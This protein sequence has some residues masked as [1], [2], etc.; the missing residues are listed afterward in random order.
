MVDIRL[1]VGTVDLVSSESL[2]SVHRCE[3]AW[4]RL[5]SLD[6]PDQ[7]R[8]V[9]SHRLFAR[10]DRKFLVDERRSDD[11]QHA[12]GLGHRVGPDAIRQAS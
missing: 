5:L 11:L 1:K 8:T 12:H 2:G 3:S 9:W 10:S 7:L 4:I 6:I